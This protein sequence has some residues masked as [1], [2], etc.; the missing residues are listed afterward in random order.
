MLACLCL[1]TV[2][3]CSK[4]RV[5]VPIFTL[6][7][8]FLLWNTHEPCKHNIPKTRYDHRSHAG[9]RECNAKNLSGRGKKIDRFPAS[10]LSP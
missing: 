9:K 6:V 8:H 2:Q 7:A 10:W 1:V 3:S 5:R 4:A